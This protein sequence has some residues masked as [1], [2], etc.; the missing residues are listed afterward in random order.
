MCITP[1][2]GRL[3]KEDHRFWASL[4]YTVR[5][6]DPVLKEKRNQRETESMMGMW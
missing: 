6:Q 1:A 4:G 2:C 5:Q 3:R